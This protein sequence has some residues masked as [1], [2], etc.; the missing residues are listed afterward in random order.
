MK[1]IIVQEFDYDKTPI[2]V[3][4]K[5]HFNTEGS[6]PED[7]ILITTPFKTYMANPEDKILYIQDKAY[8]SEELLKVIEKA[9]MY[10]GLCE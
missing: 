9:E 10:D 4:R 1:K 3:A 2:D 6:L 8:S 5:F 7:Y